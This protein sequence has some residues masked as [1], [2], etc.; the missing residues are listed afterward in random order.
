ML[1]E[2]MKFHQLN[3]EYKVFVRKQDKKLNFVENKQ[4]YFCDFW[5]NNKVIEFDGTYWHS[6]EGAAER[7][8]KRDQYFT[9]RGI[10]VLRIKEEDWYSDP[11]QVIENC[12]SFL[13]N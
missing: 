11:Q 3:K 5:C 2:Q 12:L 9:F 10:L 1:Q 8:R 7:D 13:N 4:V 6:I